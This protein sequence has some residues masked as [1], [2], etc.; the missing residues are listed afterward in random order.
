MRTNI[1]LDD[2]LVDEAARLTGIR[3]KRA[4]VREALRTLIDTHRRLSLLDLDGK[5]EFAAGYDHRTL[6]E[7]SR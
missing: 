6:R 7:R 3:T 5:I 1:V 2:D 4:L